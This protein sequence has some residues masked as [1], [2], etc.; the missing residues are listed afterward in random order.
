MAKLLVYKEKTLFLLS[1]TIK[2]TQEI[3]LLLIKT[4]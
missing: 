3:N 2:K 1:N 4:H